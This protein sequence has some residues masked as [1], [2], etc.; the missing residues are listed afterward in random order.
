MALAAAT[1]VTRGSTGK[2]S[3]SPTSA[4]SSVMVQELRRQLDEGQRLRGLEVDRPSR[5]GAEGFAVEDHVPAL[6]FYGDLVGFLEMHPAD[7]RPPELSGDAG[8]ERRQHRSRTLLDGQ[9]LQDTL[10]PA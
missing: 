8:E 9:E 7:L 1:A 5:L 6:A 4:R 3:S 10:S 2:L